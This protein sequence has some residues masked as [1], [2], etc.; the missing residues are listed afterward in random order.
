[1]KKFLTL[2]LLIISFLL[3]SVPDIVFAGVKTKAAL[4][5]MNAIDFHWIRLRHAALAKV[6]EFAAAGDEIELI[7]L[8]PKVYD[9]QKQI[10]LIREAIAEKVNYIIIG[11]LDPTEENEALQEALNAG[12][13]IIYVDSPATLKS[14]ATYATDNFSGGVEM[15]N[16]LKKFLNEQGITEGIIAVINAISHAPS[17]IKREEGFLSALKDTKFMFVSHHYFDNDSSKAEEIAKNMVD[18]GV[19]AIYGTDHYATFGASTA[20]KNASGE[21][22]VYCVGWDASDENLSQIEEGC[23]LACVAQNPEIMGKRAVS[24]VVEMEKGK[25]FDEIENDTGI[26]IIT[27]EN[28]SKFK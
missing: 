9:I 6:E 15:G 3:L 10:E 19:I 23:L 14:S 12:I 25:N 1:M 22:K 24:A 28:I 13:K 7:C 21:N 16:Y 11:C 26:F 5:T 8:T 20:I 2:L 17:C 27:K 18:N 4:I